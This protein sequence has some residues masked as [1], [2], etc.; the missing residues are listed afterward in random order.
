MMEEMHTEDFERELRSVERELYERF[1][2]QFDLNASLHRKISDVLDDKEMVIKL[3]S[4]FQRTINFLFLRSYRLHWTVMV[5]CQKGFGPEASI[6]L[7]S[8]MEQVVNM[9]WIGHKDPDHRADLFVD[10]HHVAI[11]KL[12]DNYD[13]YG[14]FPCLTE[15]EKQLMES[16]EEVERHYADVRHKYPDENRWCPK[17]VRTRAD[18]ICVSSDWD[19]YYW[20]FSF[21]VHSNAASQHEFVIQEGTRSL[22]V[23]GPSQAM[24]HDV[25]QLSCKYLLL[26]FDMWNKTFE[27]GLGDLVE[28][29]S[30]QLADISFVHEEKEGNKHGEDPSPSCDARK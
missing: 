25:L 15:A 21:F 4:D 13:K 14:R 18:D 16:R 17:H 8:L 12:Y 6:L 9:A 11:K 26:A 23:V 24:I 1:R 10:Y 28:N 20:Y 19:F 30:V 5:M 7:R 22:C 3:E 27:L 2:K 29:F